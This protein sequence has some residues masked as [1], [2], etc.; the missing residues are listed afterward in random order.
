M[1]SHDRDIFDELTRRRLSFGNDTDIMAITLF[2]S[3]NYGTDT[4]DSD[5]DC[6]VWVVPDIRDVAWAKSPYSHTRQETDGS[7]TDVKDVRHICQQLLK[8]NINFLESLVTPYVSKDPD[9]GWAFEEL[10]EHAETIASHD[11]TRMVNAVQ[12]QAHMQHKKL[13]NTD[14]DLLRGKALANML[15]CENFLIAR[16]GERPQNHTT[17]DNS[18]ADAIRVFPHHPRKG[19]VEL[20]TRGVKGKGVDNLAT[21]IM[22][23]IDTRANIIKDQDWVQ[24]QDDH[25]KNIIERWLVRRV[26]AFS[27]EFPRKDIS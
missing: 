9:I 25:A 15:R 10:R 19:L 13:L 1:T 18:F 23:N 20:K 7:H 22:A 2:G 17:F 6:M 27:T 24:Q 16:F 12:G 8:Q 5:I 21:V 3:Q 26:M 11:P 4:P 14:D